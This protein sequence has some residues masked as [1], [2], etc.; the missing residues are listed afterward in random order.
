MTWRAAWQIVTCFIL[1]ALFVP[2]LVMLITL[3]FG[4]Q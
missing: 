1:P 4:A 3:A 2:I